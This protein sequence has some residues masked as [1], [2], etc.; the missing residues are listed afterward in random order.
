MISSN[1]SQIEVN[2]EGIK[3]RHFNMKKIAGIEIT[4]WNKKIIIHE[5]TGMSKEGM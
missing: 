5:N 3:G 2:N 1:L 4:F